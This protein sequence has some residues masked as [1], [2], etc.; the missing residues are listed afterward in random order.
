MALVLD[1][2]ASV[3]DDRIISALGE[4]VS[5]FHITLPAP[6]RTFVTSKKVQ[7]DFVSV[8]RVAM[9]HIKNLRPSPVILHIFPAMPSSLVIRAG[10][11][12]MPK[13]DLPVVLYEQADQ[14][15]GFFEALIIGG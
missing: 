12:Y 14:A 13:A 1:L 8:F 11:D 3:A 9:E 6:C 10:M 7:D 5:I 15:D 2:S 4:S